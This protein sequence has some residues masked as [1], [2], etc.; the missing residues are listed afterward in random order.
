MADFTITR[1]TW[2]IAHVTA[3]D[4]ATAFAAQGYCAAADRI[5]QMEYDRLKAAGR[6]SEVVGAAGVREDT[7]F[8]RIGVEAAARRDWEDLSDEAKAMTTA[9]AAGVN[10]WLDENRES[11]PPEFDHHPFAPAQWEAWHC[12]AVYKVRHVFMGTFMRKLWR[13]TVVRAAG[14]EIAGAMRGDPNAI[15]PIAPADGPAIDLL[16]GAVAALAAAADDLAAIPDTDGGSNSWAVH[17]SRT[18]SGKPILA[19]DSHRGIEFPNVY[20][21][22]HMACDA[23]DVIGF[24]F[25]GVPGF[26]HFGHNADV[27]WCITHAMCDDTDVF[28]EAPDAV[29]ERTTETILVRDAEPVE[30]VTGRS[31]RGPYVLGALGVG[32][33]T[34]DSK[35]L[36]VDWT[37]LRADSTFECLRPMLTATSCDE[38]E[39]AVR[40]WVIPANSLL[41]ADVAGDISFKIRGRIIE[42]PP[43]NR[44]TPVPGD[45]AHGWEGLEPVPFDDLQHWRNPERGF[46]VTA[47]NRVSDHGPYISLDFAGSSRHDRIV[48]LLG[49]L[50]DATVADMTSIHADVRSLTAPAICDIIAGLSPRTELGVAA[51]D[52]VAEWD[53]RVTAD[54]A[55]AVVYGTFRQAWAN[56]VEQRLGL[57][58]TTLGEPGWPRALDASRMHFDGCT[59]LL[60]RGGWELVPGIGD[61]SDR[62]ALLSALLDQVATETAAERGADISAW[63]WD[64]QHIMVSPH[65]LA[66]GIAAAADLHP[67]VFGVAGDGETVRAGGVA[68]IHGLRCYLSSCAR[69]VFDVAD[70]DRSGWSVPHGVS[71]VRGSGHDLDQRDAWAAVELVPMAYSEAAVAAAATST[72]TVELP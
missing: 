55:A 38:L 58:A 63:R 46:L 49:D 4:A 36:C 45:D 70:W 5:W 61:E 32:D 51:R 66:L 39:E 56:E 10:R 25:P 72:S 35:V 64:D 68:P 6:W 26:A 31:P 11:L 3:P 17:G 44:W 12:S 67:P 47:N 59:S 21:Q 40:Q 54:S 62:D 30:I 28:V 14:P 50:D 34:D 57:R 7:F 71:G 23:F 29:T 69:Y 22:F 48:D 20:L 13:G 65:P 52:L 8:R 60:V 1:D 43:A 37:G 41:T 24:S 53:H 18:A 15:T 19:G 42:R 9:Y 33:D 27:A 2:G 16:D